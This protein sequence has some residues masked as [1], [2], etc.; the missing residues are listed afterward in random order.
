MS[1]P[2]T[3]GAVTEVYAFSNSQWD[4]NP[5]PA[6]VKALLINGADKLNTDPIYP[7]TKQGWGRV[8][9][10]KLIETQFYRTFY[11]DQDE[12]LQVGGKEARRYIY[13][14]GEG[15]RT[16]KFTLVWTDYVGSPSAS[17]ALV[18]DLDLVITDPDGN[19]F[20]AN[21]FNAQGHSLPGDDLGNDTINNVEK[22][23]VP[24]AKA[25]FW[26]ATIYARDTPNGP[27]NYA[28]VAQGDVVDRWRDLVADNVTLNKE[29][30]DEGEGIMFEGDIVAMGNLDFSP[31]HY[32]VYVKDLDSGEKILF[33]ENDDTRLFPWES[34]HFSHRWIAMRGDWEFVVDVDTQG[35]NEEFV[36]DNNRVVMSR[37]VKGYGMLSDLLPGGVTVWPGLE[38]HL[39]VNVL[40]TGNVPDTF[41]LST[42]GIPV[43]WKVTLDQPDLLLGVDKTGT[44]T[45]RVTP[46][47]AAKAGELYSLNVRVTSM[48]NSTYSSDL[49][50]NALVGQVHGLE[51]ELAKQGSSVLPGNTVEHIIN[52]TNTGNGEDSYSLDVFNL[53]Q[54]WEASFSEDDVTLE[55][56]VTKVVTLELGSPDDA[57]S[58]MIAALDITVTSSSGQ[59][60][61]LKAR[62][63][64]RK[65][66]GMDATMT[67]ED[68]VLPGQKVRY[69]IDIFNLGNGNDNFFYDDRVPKGWHSTIPIPEVLGLEAFESFNVTGELFCPPNARSGDYTFKVQIYTREYLREMTVTVHVDEV[70]HASHVLLCSGSAIYPGDSTVYCVGVT[71]LSNLPTLFS[72]E[73][74]GAPLD[75]VVEYDPASANIDPF[76]EQ[77]FNITATSPK[78]TPSGFYDLRLTVSYGPR[79]ETYNLTLYVMDTTSGGGGGGGGGGDGSFL[80]D[81][82]MAI[83]VAV[84]V[85]VVL[86]ALLVVRRG[87]R[88]D[89]QLD[90]EQ[91]AG[92]GRPL[93]PPPPPAAQPVARPLPPPP[94]P[95]QPETVEE[96]LSDT[97]V[98]TRMS[99]EMDRYSADANY[100]TGATLAEEGQPVYAGDCP[101]CGGKVMEYPSGT[102]MCSNCGSQF[103]DG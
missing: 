30:V 1:C 46:P 12:P 65:T 57:L 48:G 13:Q 94:P 35:V 18:S 6:M 34:I 97:P 27:Q 90:F 80:S 85:V 76:K 62:T 60:Q 75:W 58:G 82:F 74:T 41:T 25:G 77:R 10:T 79:V 43:G 8:N 5:S 31:F 51:S 26:S 29:E 64:V 100:A 61:V 92:G 102:L 68:T 7:G 11:Y 63:Q 59:S 91:G 42:E 56:N 4:H 69:T 3:A 53:P 71:S 67:A 70:F 32:E 72:V 37:F 36:K 89:M 84:V 87:G 33:E 40:N 9:L 86:V 49:S 55:D 38:S 83:L 16:V 101:N 88:D 54:G 20:I 95:K 52:V 73:M 22:V 24:S 28:F 2:A 17:K 66:T 14:V 50:S 47:S 96:L 81:N 78:S 19:V 99:D 23:V 39:E 15:Q 98:M 93:P 45:M 21:N 103:T 44:I